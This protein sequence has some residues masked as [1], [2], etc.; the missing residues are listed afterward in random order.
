MPKYCFPS[1]FLLFVTIISALILSN[2]ITYA[3]DYSDDVSK[4]D[5]VS[6][7]VPVSCNLTGTNTDHTATISNGTY[8]SDIGTTTL[9]VSCND[10]EGFAIYAIGYTDE[11]EG[12]NVLTSPVAETPISVP[13]R[14][15]ATM[16]YSFGT[17]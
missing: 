1:C 16:V 14:R 6:I 11:T 15:L 5:N 13:L 9:N 4:I 17:L 3:V 10:A 8:Q 7:G 12:K 2:P